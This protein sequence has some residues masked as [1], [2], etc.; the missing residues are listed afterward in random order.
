MTKRFTYTKKEKLKS[1][2]QLEALFSKGNTLLHFPVKVFYMLPDVPIDNIVKAGVGA[3]SRNF[4]KAVQRNRIK[5]LLREAYRLNKQPLHRFLE[6][7]NRQLIVFL[8]YV[9]KGMPQ[10]SIIQNKMPVVLE[11][12]MK[13]L[14]RQVADE[15][16]PNKII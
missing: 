14:A 7:H 5:R 2:K 9:D 1:R 10:K 6:T 11:K 13:E 4:K 12:L 3:S 16:A 15:A 8:L